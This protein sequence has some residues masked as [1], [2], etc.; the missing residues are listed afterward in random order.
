MMTCYKTDTYLN[1]QDF[2]ACEIVHRQQQAIDC[3]LIELFL[4]A[5]HHDIHPCQEI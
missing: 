2:F 3:H 5:W 1:A 4:N